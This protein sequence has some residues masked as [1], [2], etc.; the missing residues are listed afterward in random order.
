[1]VTRTDVICNSNS[2]NNNHIP[3]LGSCKLNRVP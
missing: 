1:M 2:N 3:A